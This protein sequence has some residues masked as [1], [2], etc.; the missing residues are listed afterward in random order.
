MRALSTFVIVLLQ[1]GKSNM[2]LW[3]QPGAVSTHH[4]VH[5]LAVVEN[6]E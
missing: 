2:L 4:F 6:N 1:A 5:L 3:P